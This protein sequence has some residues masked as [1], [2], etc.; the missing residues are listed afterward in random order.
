MSAEI[1]IVIAEAPDAVAVPA[2]A[3]SGTSG[4]YTVR[5]LNADGNVEAR[6]VEVGLV[7]SDYAEITS[8]L[9]AGETVVTGSSADR[10]STSTTTG[11]G[12]DGFGG[13]NGLNGA[14]GV[15]PGG[16]PAGFPGTLP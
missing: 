12:R 15:P 11:S 9:T 10:T 1:T 5:V 4:A 16:P 6:A 7:A 8:G 2:I 3:L 13:M 14:G